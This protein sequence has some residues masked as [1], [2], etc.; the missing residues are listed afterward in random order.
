VS[1]RF[2]AFAALSWPCLALADEATAR[3]A[4]ERA[5]ELQKE[6]KWAEACPLYE[7]SYHDD[8]QLGA[9]LHLA[10]CHE[11]I[12]KLATAWSEFT[13]AAELARD[14]HDAREAAAKQ[15]ADS[16]ASRLAHVHIIPPA[17]PIEGLSVHRDDV[18][19]TPLLGTDIA[20]DAGD[21]EIVVS[22]PGRVTWRHKISIIDQ[23]STAT[24]SIPALDKAPDQP[25]VAATPPTTITEVRYI[26]P[27][28]ESLGPDYAVGAGI[29]A[30]VK[31]RNGNPAVLAYRA[32]IGFR[33]GRR[34]RLALY[35]EAGSIDANGS[36][37]YDMPATVASGF[38]IGPHDRFTQ[39]SYVMPG[40]ELDIHILPKHRIDPYVALAPGLRLGFVD[41]TPYEGTSAGASQSEIFPAVVVEFRGGVDFAPVANYSAWKVGAFVDA[42]LTA[43]GKEQC[44]D[45]DTHDDKN[46]ATFLTL[47]FGARS[48]LAF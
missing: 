2:V 14:S 48:V 4:F 7:A 5:E 21:H 33:I 43:F 32:D 35:A 42:A 27:P 3:V 29:E 9:L 19:V 13:D 44:D 41:W 10:A 8:P 20:V 38:D 45:C 12:G 26:A 25:R 40:V 15:E 24:V 46:G 22:A 28:V 1:W 6:G 47:M 36:C 31:L 16:L 34:L 23:P 39:C 11:Q 30:G 37:G 18:D 17:E